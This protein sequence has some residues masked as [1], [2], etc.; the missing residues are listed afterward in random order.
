MTEISLIFKLGHRSKLKTQGMLCAIWII[1][2]T[3]DNT[4]YEKF[5]TTSNLHCFS[6]FCNIQYNFNFTSQIEISLCKLSTKNLVN[7]DDVFNDVTARWQSQPYI[8]MFKWYEYIFTNNSGTLWHIFYKFHLQQQLGMFK[9]LV[10][11]QD[12]RSNNWVIRL[13][14]KSN[15]KWLKRL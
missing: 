11:S 5:V 1:S 4:F 7:N 14:S 13:K 3:S 8:F 6:Q 15:M 10:V 2:P 12:Q 9:K